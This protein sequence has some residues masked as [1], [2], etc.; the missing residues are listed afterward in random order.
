MIELALKKPT[1]NVVAITG[2]SR[3]G[4]SMLAPIVCSFKRAETLKMDYTLE[5]YPAL[6]YLGLISDNVT[7]YLMRYMVNVIIYDSMIGRNSNFR[8]SD[9][10]SIWNSSH[11]TKYVERLLTEE[12]D[13]IYDKIKEKDRL[14]IFMFHN[15]LWHAKI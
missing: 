5:Q 7:T 3:S 2:I 9:W 14:N 6:N 4:K 15:A 13:L 1:K 12:G 8:V 11:P 10:T